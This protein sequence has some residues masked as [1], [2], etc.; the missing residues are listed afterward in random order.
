MRYL[1]NVLILIVVIL[2]VIT[3][4]WE[5]HL[6]AS[7]PGQPYASTQE[8]LNFV[9]IVGTGIVAFILWQINVREDK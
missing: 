5:I 1:I 4:G 3:N 7:L 2:T 8:F 9:S 6:I